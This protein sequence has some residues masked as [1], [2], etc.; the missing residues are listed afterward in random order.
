MMTKKIIVGMKYQMN[1]KNY[2]KNKK[3][4]DEENLVE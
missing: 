3:K 4:F 2:K 1:I